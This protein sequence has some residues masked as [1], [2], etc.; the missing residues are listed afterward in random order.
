MRLFNIQGTGKLKGQ[1][2]RSGADEI[3]DM[4]GLIYQN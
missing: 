4:K 3:L 1:E 2:G